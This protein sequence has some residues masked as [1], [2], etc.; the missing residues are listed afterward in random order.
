MSRILVEGIYANPST[1]TLR[2]EDGEKYMTITEG[3]PFVI[4]NQMRA[5]H[6]V[7]VPR[8]SGH[9]TILVCRKYRDNGTV[10]EEFP[11]FHNKKMMWATSSG[12]A[13]NGVWHTYREPQ[14][15]LEKALAEA[16]VGRSVIEKVEKIDE[17]FILGGE[18][19]YGVIHKWGYRLWSDGAEKCLEDIDRY[20]YPCHL[21]GG[22]WAVYAEV[23]TYM[24]G[25]T[26][27][28]ITR[29]LVTPEGEA[30]AATC[31]REIS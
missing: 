18:L 20:T 14:T 19:D 28:E 11:L 23:H 12:S 21:T 4:D 27:N 1:Y 26:H 6:P 17:E 13:R 15:D 25:H 31:V 2:K 10:M 16:G 24:N 5:W 3:E 29:V 8:K 7:R 9:G 22:T 30:A